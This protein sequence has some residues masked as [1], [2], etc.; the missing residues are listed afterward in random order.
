MAPRKTEVLDAINWDRPGGKITTPSLLKVRKEAD[1]ESKTWIPTFRRHTLRKFEDERKHEEM[2]SALDD[3]VPGNREQWGN[4]ITG[5]ISSLKKKGRLSKVQNYFSGCG[6]L[7]SLFGQTSNEETTILIPNSPDRSPLLGIPIEVRENIY[8]FLLSHSK[9]V[10]VGPDW[11]SCHGKILRYNSLQYVCKQIGDEASKFMYSQNVFLAM[12][13]ETPKSRAYERTLFI[14]PKFLS[15]FRNVVINCPMENFDMGWH[16]KAA[17]A[18]GKL[19]GA[20][21]VLQSLTIV[22]CP[23]RGVGKLTTAV[24]LEEN[25]IHFADF[26]YSPG[27][28]MMSIKKLRL[29]FLNIIVKKSITTTIGNIPFTSKVRRLLISVDLTHLQTNTACEGGFSNEETVAIV[30]QRA[31]SVETE[32][33]K[34]KERFEAIF[35]DCDKALQENLC[36]ELAEDEAIT[37]G[38]ALATRK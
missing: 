27:P 33:N 24:G 4:L 20:K 7:A 36:R 3:Q 13:R 29:K 26:F 31:F 28:L 5:E 1:H 15:L 18:V 9:P 34:L 35:E 23:T 30:R 8:G 22:V 14:D 11:E 10:V 21:P 6:S 2:I 32:L 37:D 25:P 19:A 12:L 16:K 38:K 17:L